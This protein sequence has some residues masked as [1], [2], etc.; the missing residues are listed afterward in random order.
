MPSLNTGCLSVV[1]VALL[2][3]GTQ[4]YAQETPTLEFVTEF[5]QF[6]FYTQPP[7]GEP[8]NTIPP[9]G[10]ADPTGVTF[11]S[12]TRLAIADYGNLKLQ[13]CDTTG[14]NCEWFGADGSF[15]RN[16]VGTFDRPHGVEATPDGRVLIADEDNHWIQSCDLNRNC[17]FSGTSGSEN[18]EPS[19]GLGRWAFPNDVAVDGSGRIYGLDTGNNRIQILEAEDLRVQ[20]SFMGSG[21]GPG[22]IQGARGLDVDA[23][24]RVVIADTGNH[25]IQVCDTSA[26]CTVFGSQG[27]G[28]GQFSA[29][30]GVEVD[31]LGRIWIADTGNNRIQACS[32]EGECTAFGPGG[33]Y[34]FNAPHDV[35]VHPNGTVAVADTTNNRIRIFRTEAVGF[36]FNAGY[37][38]AWFDPDT[39]GQGFFINVFP[40]QGLVFLANFTFDTERPPQDVAAILGEPGHRWLTGQ[41]AFDG[42]TATLSVTLTRG[43][44]FDSALPGVEN[45]ENYGTYTLEVLGCD[46]I[47]LSYDLPAIPQQGTIDLERVVK[48]NIAVCEA[49]NAP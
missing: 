17:R 15:G 28:V 47:R 9:E 34:E 12:G 40:D 22:Q 14:A 43:G 27:S 24:G 11:L 18:N 4:A 29:P 2:T 35:A 37:N 16:S 26:N 10:F 21:S 32:Y 38:D 45:V 6:G 39:A 5:G 13:F 31:A 25:R 36:S 23:D 42:D 3:A 44:V 30:V 7:F 48:D 49:L 1:A 41:G 46:A 33:S 19:S 20:K 8:P